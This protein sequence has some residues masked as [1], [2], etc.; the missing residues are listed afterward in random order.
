MRSLWTGAISFGLV[1]IAVRLYTATEEH[2]FRFNQ[3]HR[4]DGGR[5]RYKRTCEACG[6]EV[7]FADIA[8]GYEL[9]DGRVVQLEK[10]DFDTLPVSSNKAIDVLEFVPAEE[11]DPIY[12]QKT[13]Y[14]EPD[15]AAVRPYVL[16][17]TA[18]EQA[19][20]LA[21][22]KITIRQRESLA[23]LR[24]SDDVLMLHTMLWPDEIRKPD[25]GFLS[26]DIEVRP[27]E[28]K[29]AASLVDTM[30]GSFTPEEFVDDYRDALETMIEAK[31]E[32]TE[33]PQQAEEAD[34]GDVIDLMTA[35]E[36]S[37]EKARSRRSGTEP[38]A[39]PKNKAKGKSGKRTA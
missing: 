33:L 29:M 3:V 15:K 24:A 31:A 9:A 27:Q 11:I 22:V 13:Y 16:L 18:L 25:F 21:V 10:E 6:Q 36:R 7:D 39:E 37:V 5:I 4:E 8:K 12:F 19:E 38:K 14:L 17:R 32:G 1:T 2:D 23:V 30:A 26:Q 28:L 20:Q 34:S 35:L